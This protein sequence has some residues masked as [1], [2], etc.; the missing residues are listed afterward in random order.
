VKQRLCVVTPRA[1]PVALCALAIVLVGARAEPGP[2]PSAP[3]QRPERPYRGL[4]GG[5]RADLSQSLVVGGGL[6]A[7]HVMRS[8]GVVLFDGNGN[9]VP[10]TATFGFGSANVGYNLSLPRLTVSAS[11]LGSAD[12]QPRNDVVATRYSFGAGATY[13]ATPGL[14]LA[15]GVSAMPLSARTALE[16]VTDLAGT[17]P[18]DDIE[19]VLESNGVYVY[20]VFATA[21]Y[22]RAITGRLRF[23]AD[24]GYSTGF[25]TGQIV[26]VNSH[27]AGA[28]LSYALTRNLNFHAGYTYYLGFFTQNGDTTVT[29]SGRIDL[30]VDYTKGKTIKLA[31]RT[32]LGF[33]A[34]LGAVS[35]AHTV[36]FNV[37]GNVNL[38]HEIGR[39]WLAQIGYARN[40][41]FVSAF[42]Q[43]VLS[44][45]VNAQFG[46]LINRRLNF[47]SFAGASRGLIGFGTANGFFVVQAG[48]NLTYAISRYAG[49]V[50][51]YGFSESQ[52]DDSVALV[53]GLFPKDTVQVFHVLFTLQAPIWQTRRR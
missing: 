24:Y 36:H 26:D 6:G 47:N 48:A 41:G 23:L 9:R 20:S 49:L 51:A 43:P 17:P 29:R 28:R 52:F 22:Q 38:T 31:R 18:H 32:T 11:W 5:G 25:Y 1:W 3:S 15:A 37:I 53:P 50:A 7:A 35:D 8:E 33:G 45:S 4:F 34:G 42:A 30:G 14:T 46:G 40:F 19:N 13:L 44:D 12:F 21:A 39:S 16:T 2:P 27:S 10:A